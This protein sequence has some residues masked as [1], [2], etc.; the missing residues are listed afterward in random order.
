ME[1][2]EIEMLTDAFTEL[3]DLELDLE[4]LA[5]GVLTADL[6]E[7]FTVGTTM[8]I[9]GSFTEGS[10]TEGSFTELLALGMLT[11]GLLELFKVGIGMWIEGSFTDELDF[12]VE[13]ELIFLDEEDELSFLLEDEEAGFLLEED[14]FL[15]EA[16]GARVTVDFLM[17]TGLVTLVNF[18][19][20]ERVSFLLET[21]LTAVDA[22]AVLEDF[23][24]LV[25]AFLVLLLLTFLVLEGFLIEETLGMEMVV[26]LI[27]GA[28][29]VPEIPIVTVAPAVTPTPSRGSRLSRRTL[30]ATSPKVS[31]LLS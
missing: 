21:G 10:L 20:L 3:L 26:G 19:M 4:L 13:E 17:V 7:L 22:F 15:L 6:L 8:G 31:S 29:A 14:D 27:V 18:K 24:E 25:L 1:P 23:F 2:R 28:L 12:L 5:L 30:S 9:E 11:A 16:T